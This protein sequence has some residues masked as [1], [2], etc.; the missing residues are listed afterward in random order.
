MMKLGKPL[1]WDEDYKDDFEMQDEFLEE[2]NIPT[3]NNFQHFQFYDVIQ[4]LIKVYLVNHEMRKKA[5]GLAD[6]DSF[7]TDSSM[8]DEGEEEE[9]EQSPG[10]RIESEKAGS[11]PKKRAKRQATLFIDQEEK[12]KLRLEYEFESLDDEK[13]DIMDV[14]DIKAKENRIM[15]PFISKQD[16]TFTS[17]HFKAARKILVALKRL[18]QLKLER[19]ANAIYGK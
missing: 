8:N 11:P 15:K 16:P 3:Y 17:A 10:G 4:A 19:E 7:R 13:Q 9:V 12:I 1:G 2:L 14:E 6:D 18:R 5:A